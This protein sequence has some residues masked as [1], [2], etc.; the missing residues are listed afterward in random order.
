MEQVMKK[1]RN[2]KVSDSIESSVDDRVQI[3]AYSQAQPP[4]LRAICDALRELI[5]SAI[6]E[7]MSKVWHGS[8]VWFIDGN[9]VV[10]YSAAA[11]G[12]KLL[13]WNGQA[14]D[15]PLLKPVGKYRAAEA[16]FADADDID[17]QAI[18]RWLK[19]AKAVVFDSKSFFQKLRQQ[20]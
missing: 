1:P 9:P 2:S 10:G 12:V 6:P 15:E 20:K 16:V 18:D 5:D 17:P 4:A 7:A 8:P 19:K 13:F 14:F 11:K 3:S